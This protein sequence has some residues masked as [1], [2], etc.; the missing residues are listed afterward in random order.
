VFE[1]VTSEEGLALGLNLSPFF[2]SGF[3]KKVLRAKL[4]IE[5][6]EDLEKGDQ[7]D[8]VFNVFLIRV[9]LKTEQNI[10]NR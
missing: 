10:K 3:A 1:F 5:G 2:N 9:L 4:D 7:L 8:N 6:A